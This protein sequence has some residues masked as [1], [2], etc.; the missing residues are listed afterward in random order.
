MYCIVHM[1]S[2]S[3]CLFCEAIMLRTLHLVSCTVLVCGYP[4]TVKHFILD[5]EGILS[6][7]V[8]SDNSEIVFL[9]LAWL[10]Q[11]LKLIP[12]LYQKTMFWIVTLL[13]IN[14]MQNSVT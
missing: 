2:A 8:L 5:I 10:T 9:A 13:I 6:L 3:A 7:E 1:Y 4:A 11:H 14:V 12:L